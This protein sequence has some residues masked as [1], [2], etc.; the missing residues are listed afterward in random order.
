MD[1]LLGS[2]MR[3]R[4]AWVVSVLFLLLGVLLIGMV[5][6]AEREPTATDSMPD[7]TQSTRVVEL[8][9]KFPAGDDSAAIVLFSSDEP[10]SPD[11]LAELQQRFAE[12]A[13]DPEK[14][15]GGS[16][17]RARASARTGPR[18]SA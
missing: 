9:E 14:G 3:R 6:Q 10:L 7:G 12:V 2:L 8:Q 17:R 1:T 18:R 15:P 5:G 13:P 11:T 16:A 4:R